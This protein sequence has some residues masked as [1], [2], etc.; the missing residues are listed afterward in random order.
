MRVSDMNAIKAAAAP[1]AAGEP[2]ARGAR[3]RGRPPLMTPAAVL[4]RIRQLAAGVDGLYRVHIRHSGLYARARR[5]FG[6]WSGAVSA[7][8]MDY[9]EILER[10]RRRSIETRRHRRRQRVAVVR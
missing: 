3:P 7:A 1:R 4:E 6:S 8:G 2:G 10:A 9:A 5:L